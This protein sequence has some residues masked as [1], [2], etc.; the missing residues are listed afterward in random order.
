MRDTGVGISPDLLPKLFEP[1]A[2]GEPGLD[3]SRGGLGLGLALVKELVGLHGGTVGASSAGRG[4]GSEFVVRLPAFDVAN[5][6]PSRANVPRRR[7]RRLRIVIIEDNVDA[8]EGLQDVLKFLGHEVAVARDGDEGVAAVREF[9]PDLVLCDLGLPGI[10]GYEVARRLRA[11]P[12]TRGVYLVALS[13]Y[14]ERGDV[15]EASTA[16]FERHLSKPLSMKSIEHLLLE[17]SLGEEF[18]GTPR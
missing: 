10:D 11:D 2:Q 9:Q 12:D 3:R 17:M 8:G 6:Q 14:A 16:G 1:F 7:A 4:L 18:S 5:V 13:G 15:T